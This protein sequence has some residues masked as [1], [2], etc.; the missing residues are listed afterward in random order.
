M[1]NPDLLNIAIIVICGVVFHYL[2]KAGEAFM[3]GWNEEKAR[4]IREGTW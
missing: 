1:D 2:T 3:L 4:R